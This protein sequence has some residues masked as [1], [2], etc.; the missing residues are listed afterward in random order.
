MEPTRELKQA[1]I[2]YPNGKVEAFT[3]L[4]EESQRYLYVCI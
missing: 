1:V 4:Y 2:D 3:T